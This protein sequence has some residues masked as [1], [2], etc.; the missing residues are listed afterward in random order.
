MCLT[1]RRGGKLFFPKEDIAFEDGPIA[2]WLRIRHYLKYNPVVAAGNAQPGKTALET[3]DYRYLGF[4]Q[5]VDTDKDSKN[6]GK[7]VREVQP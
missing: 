1:E 3:T 4:A 6:Y 2:L 7:A 5:G